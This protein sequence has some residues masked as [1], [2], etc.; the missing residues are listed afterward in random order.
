MALIKPKGEDPKSKLKVTYEK[1]NVTPNADNKKKMEEYNTSLSAYKAAEGKYKSDVETYNKQMKAYNEQPKTN[2]KDVQ[3]KFAGGGR[4]LSGQELEK[5]NAGK[6]GERGG[7]SAKKVYVAKDYSSDKEY[8]GYFHEELNK[9]IAPKKHTLAEPKQPELSL[10]R[11]PMLKAK[12]IETAAPKKL[13]ERKT[14]EAPTW[15][16]PSKIS[17]KTKTSFS[18]ARNAARNEGKLGSARV[19]NQTIKT[20]VGGREYKKEGGQAKAYF[21]G[22]EGASK[23]DIKDRQNAIKAE[24]KELRQGIKDVRKGAAAPVESMTKGERIKG[25]REE[26]KGL[27]AENKQAKMAKQYVKKAGAEYYGVNAGESSSTQSKVKYYTPEAMT[28]YRDSMNNPAN[29]NTISAKMKNMK[30]D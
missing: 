4:Y 24:K 7:L 15:E 16:E 10:E 3:T 13:A 25:Y 18:T 14:E 29:R 27:R 6:S 17:T 1:E 23:F 5:W 26:I 2:R 22:F 20:M 28:G 11:M 21:G 30:K 8:K 9:P 12:K 19:A